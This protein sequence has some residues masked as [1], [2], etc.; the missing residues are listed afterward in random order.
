M[1][2]SNSQKLAVQ[3]LFFKRTVGDDFITVGHCE[4]KDIDKDID[5]RA[6]RKENKNQFERYNHGLPNL[7]YTNGLDFHFYKNGELINEVR[8]RDFAV[9]IS[10]IKRR[11]PDLVEALKSF[12]A[13]RL[14]T[15]TSAKR[16]ASLT[17][18]Y[19]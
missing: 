1:N 9:G 8:I 5:P 3:I 6:M 14:Q 10:P 11:Y 7:I 19:S 13:E 15:I 12:A 16:L 2:P 17:A 4:A 18:K